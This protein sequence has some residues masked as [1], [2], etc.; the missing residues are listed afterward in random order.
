M[1]GLLLLLS[2]RS[3]FLQVS[4]DMQ[5]PEANLGQLMGEVQRMLEA[6][7]K[8]QNHLVLEKSTNGK[9]FAERTLLKH[10][11]TWGLFK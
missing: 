3:V 5:R 4:S 1:Q 9:K 8:G 11:I 10:P 7:L 6:P 2:R